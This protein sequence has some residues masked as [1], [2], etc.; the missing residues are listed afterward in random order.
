KP[1]ADENLKHLHEAEKEV[2]EAFKN[3]QRVIF[4]Q[5]NSR[6]A[7]GFNYAE[8]E[9]APKAEQE[10]LVTRY[11]IARLKDD[12]TVQAAQAGLR[13]FKP[14]V[15]VALDLGILHLRRARGMDEAARKQELTQAEETFKAVRGVAGARADLQLGQVYYWMGRQAEG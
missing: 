9:H 5:L 11:V 3:A 6:N 2:E 13:K 12:G 10:R 14:V 15:D 8:Y 7:P 4:E 1:Y